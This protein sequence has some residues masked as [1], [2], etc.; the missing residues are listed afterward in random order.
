MCRSIGSVTLTYFP[1][2]DLDRWQMYAKYQ[3]ANYCV[4]AEVLENMEYE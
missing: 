1:W 3:E 2:V 4:I